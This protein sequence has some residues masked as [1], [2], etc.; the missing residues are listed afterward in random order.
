MLKSD[1]KIIEASINETREALKKAADRLEKAQGS[2]K[3][4]AFSHLQAISA[5]DVR[6]F[7]KK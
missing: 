4:A 1:M 7:L 5:S 2:D 6:D 3:V